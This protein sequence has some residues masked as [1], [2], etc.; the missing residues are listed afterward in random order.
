MCGLL[1]GSMRILVTWN[2]S[3]TIASQP[4]WHTHTGERRDYLKE[5]NELS[6][7]LLWDSFFYRHSLSKW[8]YFLPDT[9]AFA[10][11]VDTVIWPAMPD[12][13]LVKDVTVEKGDVGNGL[14]NFTVTMEPFNC[15]DNFG[16]FR[17]SHTQVYSL[18]GSCMRLQWFIYTKIVFLQNMYGF[19]ITM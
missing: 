7:S 5:N 8:L 10:D 14:F 6:L 15:G 1:G 9:D 19:H 11:V 12:G 17:E 13:E 3:I 4:T 18:A 16:L 2:W